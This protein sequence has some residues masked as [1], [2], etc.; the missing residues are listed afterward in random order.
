MHIW[1]TLKSITHRA[2]PTAAGAAKAD[3][4][5]AGAA[6]TTNA[7]APHMTPADTNARIFVE[8]FSYVGETGF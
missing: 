5:S 3:D 1:P 6:G 2:K 4:R 8:T 7:A